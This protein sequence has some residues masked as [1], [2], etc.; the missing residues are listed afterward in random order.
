MCSLASSCVA[1]GATDKEAH[2]TLFIEPLVCGDALIIAALA[3]V[4]TSRH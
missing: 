3:A 4:L 2:E 1:P